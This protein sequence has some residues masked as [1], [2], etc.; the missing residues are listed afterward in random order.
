MKTYIANCSFKGLLSSVNL[1]ISVNDRV[2][3]KLDNIFITYDGK[4]WD[5]TCQFRLNVRILGGD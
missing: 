2:S 5:S 1:Y 4:N 3:G